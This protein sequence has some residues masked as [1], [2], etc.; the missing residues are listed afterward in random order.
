MYDLS[1]ITRDDLRLLLSTAKYEWKKYTD[2]SDKVEKCEKLIEEEKKIV[3]E[4]NYQG[5]LRFGIIIFMVCA[6]IVSY[7]SIF[8]PKTENYMIPGICLILGILL[9]FATPIHYVMA[10]RKKENA[11]SKLNE[12]EVRLPELRKK[13]Q[14]AINEFDKVWYIPDEY[15]Y[16]YALAKMLQ[17][18]DSWEAH[19]WKEVTAL[20]K[21]HLH[22]TT[23][24]E[25]T[26]IAADEAIKQTEIARQTRNAARTAAA[27]A[28]IGALRK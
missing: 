12:Y 17:Y 7:F 22:D 23:V 28:I 5:C 20:Y 9:L 3:D 1:T 19:N 21:R 6:A 4:N 15:C 10:K 26:R 8:D 14:E 16:D 27:G 2:C 24:E 25:N 11:Q 13:K 18:I